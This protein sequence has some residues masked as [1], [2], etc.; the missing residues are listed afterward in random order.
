MTHSSKLWGQTESVNAPA[1]RPAHAASARGPQRTQSPHAHRYGPGASSRPGLRGANGPGPADTSLAARL[2]LQAA[3]HKCLHSRGNLQVPAGRGSSR[4]LSRG[5][6]PWCKYSLLSI[7]SHQR[8]GRAAG[9][10]GWRGRGRRRRCGIPLFSIRS[11]RV[12]STYG[13]QPETTDTGKVV[14][15]LGRGAFSAS[16]ILVVCFVVIFKIIL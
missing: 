8:Q 13:N 12:H 7:P 4:G 16:V 2:L 10:R 9:L 11:N 14:A 3:G 1:P 15:R 5:P 6:F